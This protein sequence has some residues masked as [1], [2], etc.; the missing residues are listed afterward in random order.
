VMNPVLLVAGSNVGLARESI[1]FERSG[2][3]PTLDLVA[4]KGYTSQSGSSLTS[5]SNK[6]HQKI[7][8]LQV[9]IPI[10]AGGVVNSR[11]REASFRLDE[12]MQNEEEQRRAIMRQTR[13]AYNSVM[14]GISRVNA[15]KQAVYSNQ[16]ALES[17]EAGF[18]VGTRTTVD[19][20][21]ARRE[22]FS[23]LRDYSRSRYE[24]VVNTLRLKQAAGIVSVNDIEQ[25]N[26][27]LEPRT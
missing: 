2:H 20:L 12:A 17:T 27:W 19:V 1:E 9:N 14:S 22:L 23:A 24:Y 15:L 21:N 10:Y 16:K 13:A 25:I 5:D 8:G 18:D 3:Y 4:Q 6:T 26:Q 7:I 11:T